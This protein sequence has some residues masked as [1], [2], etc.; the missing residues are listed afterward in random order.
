MT[1]RV[2]DS[3]QNED[4]TGFWHVI[5]SICDDKGRVANVGP[6]RSESISDQHAQAIRAYC[7]NVSPQ[8]EITE[9]VQRLVSFA[10]TLLTCVVPCYSVNL[11]LPGGYIVTRYRRLGVI[12]IANCIM[13]VKPSTNCALRGE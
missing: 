9:A 3:A 4:E 2:N 6:L 8:N 1:T 11:F 13:H 10:S 12:R 5:D 7:L